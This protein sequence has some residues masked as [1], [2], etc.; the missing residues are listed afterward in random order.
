VK[1]CKSTLAPSERRCRRF[2]GRFLSPA[3]S[4]A[5][6]PSEVRGS[7]IDAERETERFAT[8]VR[9]GIVLL[10]GALFVALVIVTGRFR[11]YVAVI[12]GVN[13]ALSLLAALTAN[14]RVYRPWLPWVLT[15][16][17]VVVFLAVIEL[18]PAGRRLPENYTP[19]LVGVWALFVLLAVVSLRGSAILMLYATIL[20]TL[21]LGTHLFAPAGTAAATV[22]L[23]PVFDPSRNAL[24]LALLSSTGLVLGA[25]ALRAKRT[26]LRA[27]ALARERANLARYLPARVVSLLAER[28]L[29]ELRRGRIQQAAILFVDIRGFTAMSEW[30][31]PIGVATLLNSF[32]DRAT[33]A[34]E[35]HGGVV[36][37]FIG[38]AV[39]GLFGVPE[40][41]NAD[42]RAAISA[43]RD[44][45]GSITRWSAKRS[46]EGRL[47]V[48]VGVGVHFGTVFAGVLGHEGRLEFTVIGDTV[49]VAQRVEALTKDI[50]IDLLVTGD[51]LQ[52]AYG[53]VGSDF[54]C[55]GWR[56]I[57]TQ[58]LQGR[59]S[60]IALFTLDV[61]EAPQ[62]GR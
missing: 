30:L 14:R 8:I 43:A 22:D 48:R 27:A 50:G 29:D 1:S 61:S 36:D 54:S 47:P 39:M 60:P 13:L 49:N 28:D 32:R 38:D 5:Q 62:H 7:V 56:F 42:A 33:R 11:P 53:V 41:G 46:R 9:L 23:G 20:A 12:Y 24:R 16:L 2:A 18:G 37:K 6:V 17:D 34:I 3:L 15:T 52:A 26:L 51:A 19:A 10:I 21:G 40:P 35:R 57:R 25:S 31:S 45:L 55:Y 44:L 59:N 58:L 4:L